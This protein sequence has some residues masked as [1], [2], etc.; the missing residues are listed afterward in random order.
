M[1]VIEGV[2]K[3]VIGHQPWLQRLDRFAQLVKRTKGA[4]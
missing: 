3:V 1:K 4:R 2:S